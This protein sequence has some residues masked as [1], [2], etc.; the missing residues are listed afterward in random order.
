MRKQNIAGGRNC[1]QCFYADYQYR[2]FAHCKT[3]K[4]ADFHTTG[5][6]SK[7]V[8]IFFSVSVF[9]LFFIKAVM[10]GNESFYA[11]CTLLYNAIFTVIMEELLFRGY[12]W[13]ELADGAKSD[14]QVY[15]VTSILFG[16][17]HLGY[18]DTILWRTAMFHA[19]ADIGI[20]MIWK[21]ITG[22]VFGAIL[23]FFRY[24]NKNVSA[25]ILLHSFLNLIGG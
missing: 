23:G 21:V 18:I 5:K 6:A 8:Y 20:I 16:F 24:R 12:F 4:K 14:R 17:W 10:A 1:Q 15:F 19:D 13:A 11:V 22:L 3:Q 7:R 25:P 2:S 9:L